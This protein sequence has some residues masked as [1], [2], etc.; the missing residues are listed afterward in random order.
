M[1]NSVLVSN[2]LNSDE[3]ISEF[4]GWK[5]ALTNI[6]KNRSFKL[7]DSRALQSLLVLMLVLG[8]LSLHPMALGISQLRNISASKSRVTILPDLRAQHRNGH[9]SAVAG[10]IMVEITNCNLVELQKLVTQSAFAP[11]VRGL[12]FFLLMLILLMFRDRK[13]VSFQTLSILLSGTVPIFL[14]TARLRI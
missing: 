3:P 6:A 4:L 5:Q 2:Q 14:A 1:L 7:S 10:R 13:R 11:I 9:S 12:M 8:M